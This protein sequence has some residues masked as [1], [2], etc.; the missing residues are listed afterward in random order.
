MYLN[1][2]SIYTGPDNL[3]TDNTQLSISTVYE[4]SVVTVSCAG[5]S[6]AGIKSISLG[7]EIFYQHLSLTVIIVYLLQTL[8]YLQLLPYLSPMTIQLIS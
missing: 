7:G 3:Y 6:T 2:V 5:N 1:G 4:Y 8:H